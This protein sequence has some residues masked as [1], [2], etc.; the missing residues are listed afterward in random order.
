MPTNKRQARTSTQVT[1]TTL[2]LVLQLLVLSTLK[3]GKSLTPS[4]APKGAIVGV[5]GVVRGP[6]DGTEAG[7]VLVGLEIVGDFFVELSCMLE[8]ALRQV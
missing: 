3:H 1:R 4:R 6:A 7:N 2:V 8:M 5:D